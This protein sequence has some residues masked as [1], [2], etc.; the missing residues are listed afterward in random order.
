MRA[1]DVLVRMCCEILDESRIYR[2]FFYKKVLF[3]QSCTLYRRAWEL[4]VS[5][6]DVRIDDDHLAHIHRCLIMRI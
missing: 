4:S 1:T 2:K 3:D 6:P 5:V